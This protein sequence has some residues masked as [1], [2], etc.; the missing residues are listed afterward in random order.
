MT[1]VHQVCDIYVNKSLKALIKKHYFEFR[2]ESLKGKTAVDLVGCA[3]TIPRENLVDMIEKTFDEINN[4]NTRQRW[5]SRTFEQCGQD[6]WSANLKQFEEHLCSL[7][8]NTVYS[9]MDKSNREHKLL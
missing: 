3:L 4:Q 1:S 6:P 5:I 2:Y 8:E 9:Q 7:S